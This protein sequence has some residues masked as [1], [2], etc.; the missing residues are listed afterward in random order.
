MQPFKLKYLIVIAATL[1]AST[2]LYGFRKA[3]YMTGQEIMQKVEQTHAGE[4]EAALIK[5]VTMDEEGN[6]QVR[7][8]VS[9]LCKNSHDRY[10]YM[11]RFLVP[12]EIM[13]T[14]L[15]TVEG[16]D[17]NSD[18]YLYLPGLG[19]A[20]KISGNAR[21]ASFMGS[22]FTFE[23]LRREDSSEHVYYRL[24]D[25]T[26]DGQEVY[27][28]LSA[29]GNVDIEDRK[30][31]ANRIISIDKEAFNILQIEFFDENEKLTKSFRGYDYRSAAVDGPSERP[32]RA[33]MTDNVKGTTTIMTLLKSRMNVPMDEKNFAVENLENWSPANLDDVFALFDSANPYVNVGAKD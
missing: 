4:T 7:E 10:N 14:G 25:S 21:S 1:F 17:G 3:A 32:H 28:I 13:G 11:I 9:L 15:L 19:K 26:L 20:R 6:T 29:P 12:N 2:H 24:L 31:Y 27:T 18:Q 33:V 22:D 23:D 8:F 5:M 30:G 16:E